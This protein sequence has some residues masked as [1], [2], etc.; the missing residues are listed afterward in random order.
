VTDVAALV[1]GQQIE[2]ADAWRLLAKRIPPLWPLLPRARKLVEELP[3]SQHDREGILYR[4]ALGLLKLP[5][6]G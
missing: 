6:P 2:G 3:I 1:G 5:L 4:N